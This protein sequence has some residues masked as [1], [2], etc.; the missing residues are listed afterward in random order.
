MVLRAQCVVGSVVSLIA[1]NAW[2]Q[3]VQVRTFA[4]S[5]Q[6]APGLPAG[7]SFSA[8]DAFSI[9][10]SGR[11][12]MFATVA[13]SGVTPSN[14]QGIWWDVPGNLQLVM[15]LTDP[16]P[17]Q[18][19]FNYTSTTA[20]NLSDAGIMVYGAL[21][22]PTGGGSRDSLWTI[23]PGGTPAAFAIGMQQVPGLGIGTQWS[24]FNIPN[25][26]SS[27]VMGFRAILQGPGGVNSH[28]VGT[29]SS[30]SL[31]SRDADPI[32]VLP[33]VNFA[34]IFNEYRI[35]SA[36]TFVFRSSLAGAGVTTS[37][38][39]A[40]WSRA[41]DGT[42]SL[43]ARSDDQAPGFPAGTLY[44]SFLSGPELDRSGRIAFSNAL[45]GTGVNASNNVVALLYD[46]GVATVLAR[47]GDQAPGLP[48]G[49]S[50]AGSFTVTFGGQDTLVLQA[51]L[52]GAGVVTANRTA[53]FK[54]VG[55][56]PLTLVAR[57]GN[58]APG[59]TPTVAWDEVEGNANVALNASGR[60]M[61]VA[62]LANGREGIWLEDAS[63]EL[64]LAVLEQTLFDV[65]DDPNVTVLKTVSALGFPPQ[66]GD[67]D[68]RRT[69]WSDTGEVIFRLA[70]TDATSGAFVA[71]LP[72]GCD[73]IDFNNNGVFPEDQDVVDFFN[74]LA[75]GN[76]STCDP[77]QGCNDIDFNNNQVF[78]EDQDVIDF[79]N[80]LAGGTCG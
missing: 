73:G 16:A 23:G 68:G 39:A 6:Q 61:L 27:G 1:A 19:G 45:T 38:N 34:G 29:P 62:P 40:I 77:I 13:G 51:R 58:P 7:L 25:I 4:L 20:S 36:G 70:F 67:D 48:A 46:G 17:G 15:R 8:F 59:V 9:N 57:G 18:P 50:F 10:A 56:G 65:N 21:I 5:G 53:L 11:V 72:Q 78:P 3:G 31:A 75:G 24:G 63:G 64:R 35:N 33:G 28:W 66:A 32:G 54:R 22:A 74:V 55:N 12:G 37:N 41:A 80:V 43:I 14:R 49:V 52:Q 30:L 71:K 79:F 69:A 47:E 26:T 44:G 2:A 60:L 42:L 76:P